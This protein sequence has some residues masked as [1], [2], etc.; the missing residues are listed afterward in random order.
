MFLHARI[1]GEAAIDGQADAGDETGSVIVQQEQQ[2]AHKVLFAVAEAAHGGRSKDLVGTGRRGAVLI[3]EE[4]GV[5][6]AGEEARGDGVHPD[7]DF[8][9][10]DGQPLGEV[11][12]SG[13]GAGVGR[14]LGQGQVS[15]R[16]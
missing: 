9:E 1:G 8:A 6:L 16:C 12:H 10:M 13:L 14:Y 15:W 11:G 7:A 2:C 3:V 4:A 5:L